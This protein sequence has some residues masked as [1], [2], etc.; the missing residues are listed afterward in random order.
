MTVQ[1][2]TAFDK[3]YF[4][5][6]LVS[7]YS[8][9]FQLNEDVWINIGYDE[10]LLSKKSLATFL[11]V[12]SNLGL[13]V[14]FSPLKMPSN[15]PTSGH[16]ISTITFGR[17]EL[18]SILVEKFVW[19][20]IDTIFVHGIKDL[21]EFSNALPDDFSFCALPSPLKS[22][23]RQ[24]AHKPN[25]AV[26]RSGSRYFNA[27][28]FIA[29]PV[30]W[31]NSGFAIEWKKLVEDYELYGF[32]YLDQC[33][34]NYLYSGNYRDLPRMF[35]FIPGVKDQFLDENRILHFAGP[36]KPWLF[37]PKQLIEF[38]R[39]SPLSLFFKFY[40]A[41]ELA[42]FLYA[43]K[44]RSFYLV[45]SLVKFK[46]FANINFYRSLVMRKTRTFLRILRQ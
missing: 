43:F 21:I 17:L 12:S 28:I 5:P 18:L 38:F 39:K 3:N 13:K 19:I 34:L 9:K 27:G 44:S 40:Y 6:A 31:K 41:Q 11:K 23:A 25:A 42:I 8:A 1:V 32:E 24:I 2:W 37:Q 20:D 22:N 16:I 10:K 15:L 36:A 33:V 35:N 26:L 46:F 7:L 45:F 4:Y 14:K 30:Q 29:D